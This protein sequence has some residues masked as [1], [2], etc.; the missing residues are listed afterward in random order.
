MIEKLE[1]LMALAQEKHFGRAAEVCSVS[2]PSLSLGLK[3]LEEALGVLLVERGSRFIRLTAEGER[4]LEWA[5]R[6]V[7]DAR[8]MRQDINILKRGLTGR[9]RIA[10]APAALPMTATVTGPL[11]TRHPDVQFTILSRP[12]HDIPALLENIEVDAAI[13][14]VDTELPGRFLTIPL[15]RERY[16]LLVTKDSALSRRKTVTWKTV[17]GLPLCLLTLDTE[18]RRIIEGLLRGTGESPKI[19]LESDSMSVLIAHVRTGAWVSIVPDKIAQ[20]TRI[21]DK[22]FEAIPIVEPDAV[23]TIGLVMPE[24]DPTTPLATALAAQARLTASQLLH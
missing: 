13:T 22:E 18:N 2:Q 10:V 20:S 7:G 6:I 15:Y 21:A 16:Q 4:T 11:Y 14:Y 19:M 12:A 3:Q 24:R 9:L 5:R 8:A 17:S 23:H 1:Y